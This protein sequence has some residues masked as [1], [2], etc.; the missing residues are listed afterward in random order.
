MGGQQLTNTTTHTGCACSH[1]D[2]DVHACASPATPHF[3][4]VFTQTSDGNKRFLFS[5]ALSVPRTHT[6]AHTCKESSKCS[7]FCHDVVIYERCFSQQAD[8]S[9]WKA[10]FHQSTLHSHFSA[11]PP[12][13]PRI[14]SS[15][16]CAGLPHPLL[17]QVRHVRLH[18]CVRAFVCEG[19]YGWGG[20][21]HKWALSAVRVMMQEQPKLLQKPCSSKV[22]ALSFPHTLSLSLNKHSIVYYIHMD[23]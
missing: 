14:S 19:V 3:A 22:S 20:E 9:V 1:T 15:L 12:S 5:L 13:L 11:T 23:R 8:S 6:S 17:T 2:I 18:V 16:P 10:S 21:R 4:T 7:I